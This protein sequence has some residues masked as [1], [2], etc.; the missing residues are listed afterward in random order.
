MQIGELKGRKYEIKIGEC[1]IK[2]R[3]CKIKI[4]ECEIKIRES[5]M[6]IGECNGILGNVFIEW[7]M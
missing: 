2:I 6:K 1:E 3:E 5:K 7:G 4:G